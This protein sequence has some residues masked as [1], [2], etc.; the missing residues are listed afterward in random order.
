MPY[1]LAVDGTAPPLRTWL[2]GRMEVKYVLGSQEA[3]SEAGRLGGCGL[4]ILELGGT[5]TG[6]EIQILE[7]R[8]NP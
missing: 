7:F 6:S 2:G 3:I 5:G 4:W 8:L 1:I